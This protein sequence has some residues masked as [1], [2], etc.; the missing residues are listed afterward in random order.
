MRIK[1]SERR[2]CCGVKPG[3]PVLGVLQTARQ[4]AA[5][6]LDDILLVVKKIGKGLQQRVK[7]QTLTRQLPLG[8]TDL[9]LRRP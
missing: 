9:L 4:I 8:K 7:P 3:R 6:L 5:D 2:I 1:T